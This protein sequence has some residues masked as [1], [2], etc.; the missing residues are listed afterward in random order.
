MRYD[1][2]VRAGDPL[3]ARRLLAGVAL[4]IAGDLAGCGPSSDPAPVSRPPANFGY[5]YA[6]PDCA[7]WDGRA[8]QI[9]LTTAPSDT[10]EDERPQLRLAIYPRELRIAGQTYRW[11]AEPEMAT[12]SRCTGDACQTASAGEIRLGSARP[13]SA[14]QGTITLRFGP[15]EV[16]SGGFRAVWRPRRVFCG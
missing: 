11:P 12:G 1:G 3:A 2:R 14:L 6:S 8:V 16:I 7:P 10:P 4:A 5:A 15:T 9:L 13:D